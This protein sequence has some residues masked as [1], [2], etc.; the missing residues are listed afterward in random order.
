MLVIIAYGTQKNININCHST[1]A[2][3]A[4]PSVSGIEGTL[5]LEYILI[6]ITRTQYRQCTYARQDISQVV[7]VG[8]V[9]G[10]E[11]AIPGRANFNT[12]LTTLTELTSTDV[13]P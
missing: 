6:I 8:G 3:R 2:K 10:A 7:K 12:T 13:K 1:R 5:L 9:T 4:V 11:V